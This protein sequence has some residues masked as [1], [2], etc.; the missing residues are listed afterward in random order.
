MFTRAIHVFW[1][2]SCPRVRLITNRGMKISSDA[3]ESWKLPLHS[4][5]LPEL[6]C[7]YGSRSIMPLMFVECCRPFFLWEETFRFPPHHQSASTIAVCALFFS[8]TPFGTTHTLLGTNHLE[9]EVSVF[10]SEHGNRVNR[11]QGTSM[12]HP[13]LA[14]RR[15]GNKKGVRLLAETAHASDDRSCLNVTAMPAGA[16]RIR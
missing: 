10:C 15:R 2:G 7:G 12:Y 8:L 13:A 1:C 9:F 4:K 16:F 6:Y 3:A 11:C 14:T 5:S